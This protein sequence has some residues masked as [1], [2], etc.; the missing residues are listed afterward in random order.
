MSDIWNKYYTSLKMKKRIVVYK[1]YYIMLKYKHDKNNKYLF[2]Y[3]YTY[4]KF[5]KKIMR[6]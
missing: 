4:N 1:K 6:L 5:K 3:K 2:F